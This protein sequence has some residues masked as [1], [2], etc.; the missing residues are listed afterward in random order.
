MSN[1]WLKLAASAV[2]LACGVA[3]VVIAVVLVA[4]TL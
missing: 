3:A 2:A 1:V 4:G